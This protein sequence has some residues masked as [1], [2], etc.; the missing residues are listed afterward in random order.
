M[1]AEQRKQL[2]QNELV[3]RLTR[4]WKGNDTSKSST[5]MWAVV[6]IVA[7]VVILIFAWRYYADATF[8]T[9]S[10]LWGEVQVAHEN[11]QLEQIAEANRGTPAARTAKAQLA[12][13]WLQ[14]GLGKLGSE[15]LRPTAVENVEKAR[16]AY[17]ELLKE[18]ADDLPLQ[19]EALL[20]LAKAEEALVGVPKKDNAAEERG[21]LDK[22]AEL[23][24]QLAEKHKDSLQGKSAAERASDIQKNKATILAFYKDLNAALA[25]RDMS[26]IP[27][28]P[29]I[30]PPKIDVP[31]F[32]PPSIIPPP[33]EGP[34]IDVPK[35]D[36]GKTVIPPP[37]AKTEGK[38]D[39]SKS[40]AKKDS[41]PP[42]PPK[43]EK[44]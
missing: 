14:D 31:K 10:S 8:K 23:Y 44:K 33:L 40:D 7:L 3:A 21:S 17:D 35:T 20:A 28:L 38:K 22:A 32:D 18:A 29:P 26:K 43:N 37:A 16:K 15:I 12:R 39:E 6:G 30:S 42:E 2:E 24:Q 5:T 13:G 36:A 19:R 41:K 4:W 9:R 11:S 25:K 1:K 27:D 34:K